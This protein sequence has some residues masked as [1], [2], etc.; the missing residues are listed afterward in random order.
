M[1]VAEGAGPKV[2]PV[3]WQLII[4]LVLVG[5]MMIVLASGPH[6]GSYYRLPP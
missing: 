4:I 3:N 6:Y 2:K 5:I 1:D